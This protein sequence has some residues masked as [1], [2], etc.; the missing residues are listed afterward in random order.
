MVLIQHTSQARELKG[1]ERI[2]RLGNLK[3]KALL[4]GETDMPEKLDGSD[5][6]DSAS[7]DDDAAALTTR[8][9]EM[10]HRR[11]GGDSSDSEEET[12]PYWSAEQCVS[13]PLWIEY[14][15]TCASCSGFEWRTK[16]R[17]A[18]EARAKVEQ[19]EREEK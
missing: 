15:L 19:K 17:L 4:L 16:S 2:Q 3:T 7:S 10:R 6:D 13:P 5:S 11:R 8:E 12:E 18:P 9:P 1:L 14:Q